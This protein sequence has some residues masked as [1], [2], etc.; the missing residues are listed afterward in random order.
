[1][2]S[3]VFNASGPF[4]RLKIAFGAKTGCHPPSE[5]SAGYTGKAGAV[6]LLAVSAAL[7]RLRSQVLHKVHALGAVADPHRRRHLRCPSHTGNLVHLA[8]LSSLLHL[9]RDAR[10]YAE[11][12]LRLDGS[13]SIAEQI[14]KRLAVA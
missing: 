12:A 3:I 11:E 1:M 5:Q 6:A 2:A 13:L 14:L 4:S 8:R 9:E 7:S 10:Q